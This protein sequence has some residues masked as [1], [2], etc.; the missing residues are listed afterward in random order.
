MEQV[1]QHRHLHPRRAMVP[2][3]S[4][5]QTL[6]VIH[7][8][9][10]LSQVMECLQLLRVATGIK[11]QLNLG[12]PAMGL[13]KDR[14]PIPLLMDRPNS[15]L[16]LQEAMG[17]L[18]LFSLDILI[19]SHH[20]LAILNQIQVLNVPHHPVMVQLLSKGMDMVHHQLVNQVMV[21]GHH[22]ITLMVVGTPSILLMALQHQLLSLFNRVE[23]PSHP[24]VRH[25]W[26]LG[27]QLSLFVACTFDGG[28]LY[29]CG[30]GLVRFSDM[31]KT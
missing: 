12:I 31:F 16:V 7:L 19:H 13:P 28:L 17:S 27:I 10:L 26:R 30:L 29:S 5:A 6:P 15:H 8:K 24:K 3:N 11:H 14:N 25:M 22:L 23:Y 20:H 2:V 18:H 9:E 4:L 21:R 1:I